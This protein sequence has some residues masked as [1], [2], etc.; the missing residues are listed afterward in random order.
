MR[1]WWPPTMTVACWSFRETSVHGDGHPYG[2][3]PT[4][5][6]PLTIALTAMSQA[7]RGEPR[8][9][10]PHYLPDSILPSAACEL[11]C[12]TIIH[13]GRNRNGTGYSLGPVLTSASY[14]VLTSAT[15]ISPSGLQHA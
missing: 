3:P 11:D 8:L 6:S 10:R 5:M 13:K 4:T 7:L 12:G 15:Q 1:D 2:L 14:L 9:Y